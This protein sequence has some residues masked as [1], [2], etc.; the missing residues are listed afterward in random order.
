MN[1]EARKNEHSVK[2]SGKKNHKGEE[3]KTVIN[4]K[5]D[6]MFLRLVSVSQQ[7]GSIERLNGGSQACDAV[8]RR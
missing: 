4:Q 6:A 2:G 1:I 8:A 3:R 7:E 5:N